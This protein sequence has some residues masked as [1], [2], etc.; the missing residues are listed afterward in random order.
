MEEW[1]KVI[2]VSNYLLAAYTTPYEVVIEGVHNV[3]VTAAKLYKRI[4][5]KGSDSPFGS[6]PRMHVLFFLQM[7]IRYGYAYSFFAKG[8]EEAALRIDES[9][10]EDELKAYALFFLNVAYLDL[11]Q[12]DTFDF[13]LERVTNSLPVDLQL[14]LSHE[15]RKE[16][17]ER[18]S[19]MRKQDRH[20][21]RVLTADK[22]LNDY[23]KALYE[24]PV[25]TLVKQEQ[26]TKVRQQKRKELVDSPRPRGRR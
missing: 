17:A 26:R 13:M 20:L 23:V 9:D 21:R 14:A 15:G 2:N 8:I 7:F 19:L 11:K 12:T 5:T 3:A 16:A 22:K 18:S 24:Q 25:N 4:I 6:L 10:L 1:L